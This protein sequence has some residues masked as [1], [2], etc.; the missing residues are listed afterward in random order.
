MVGD[1]EAVSFVVNAGDELG[2]VGVGVKG[3]G[4]GVRGGAA[5]GGGGWCAVGSGGTVGGGGLAGGGKK[6]LDGGVAGVVAG[7]VATE[8]RDVVSF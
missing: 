8:E 5:V 4:G 7:F 3:E 6:E 2:E 1:G